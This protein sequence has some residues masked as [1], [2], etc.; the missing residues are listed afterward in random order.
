[1]EKHLIYCS[2]CDRDVAVIIRSDQ[3]AEQSDITMMDV[4]CTE[5]GEHCTGTFCPVCAR[6]IPIMREELEE[7]RE[8]SAPG[9][10]RA[11]LL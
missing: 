10:E 7:L 6:A 5:I 1:M 9:S 11:S 3:N 4:L 2:A 8:E